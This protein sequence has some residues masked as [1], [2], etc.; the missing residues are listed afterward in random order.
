MFA[1]SLHWITF[2]P[3]R[4]TR[5]SFHFQLCRL[6]KQYVCI[7][8][9][10]GLTDINV[11][12]ELGNFIDGKVQGY[13]FRPPKKYKPTKQAV[14]CTRNLRGIVWNSGR[15]HY[16]EILNIFP[17]EL[18]GEYY[19]KKTEK[20]K[21]LKNLFGKDV[22]K[23]DDH[24]CPKTR[25]LVNEEIWICSSYPFRNKTTPHCAEREAYTLGK[26]PMQ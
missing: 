16:S 14:W 11:I 24:G 6:S 9:D 18:K 10:I 15:L 2:L 8:L 3:L 21:V 7:L 5:S 4:R 22:E 1:W 20:C 19:G 17:C 12:K 26:Q 25:D 23:L 13:S